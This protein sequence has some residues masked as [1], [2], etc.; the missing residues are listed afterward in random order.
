MR[1]KLKAATMPDLEYLVR[2]ADWAAG[3][4]FCWIEGL[5]DPDEWCY[6][7]WNELR[8]DSNGDDYSAEALLAA[9]EKARQ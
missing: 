9:I 6:R 4:G 3:Q 5:E 8:P 2:L 7:R 1:K